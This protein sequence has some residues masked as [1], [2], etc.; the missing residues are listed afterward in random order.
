MPNGA[1]IASYVVGSIS[2]LLLITAVFL[3]V[4]LRDKE[5][6]VVTLTPSAVPNPTLPPKSLVNLAALNIQQEFG[7][8][9]FQVIISPITSVTTTISAFPSITSPTPTITPIGPGEF[10]FNSTIGLPLQIPSEG[11]GWMAILPDASQFFGSFLNGYSAWSQANF[12]TE[13][14]KSSFE[15]YQEG[16]TTGQNFV[17]FNSGEKCPNSGSSAAPTINEYSSAVG[18]LGYS[19]IATSKDGV[20]LYIAYRQ[21]FMGNTSDQALIF[22]LL[23]LPGYIACY[24]RPLDTSGTSLDPKSSAKDWTYSCIL[25]LANVFGSQTGG[26]DEICDPITHQILTGDSFGNIIRTSK[27][28]TN[29][30]RIVAARMNYGYVK[31]NGACITVFEETPDGVHQ[32]SGVI[33]L[34]NHYAGPGKTFSSNAKITFGNDFN[35]GNNAILA[36]IRVPAAG[37]CD[38]VPEPP[39]NQIIY[40]RRN[41]TTQVW[42]FQQVIDP[43]DPTE[44]F[45][46]S[47][48]MSPDGTMA[49]VGA[50]KF[51]SGRGIGATPGIG[52]SLYLYV[53]SDDAT[54]WSMKQ[55]IIDPFA[56]QNTKGC[57]G[58]FV[59]SDPQFLVISASAN[60]NN[61]L[62]IPPTVLGTASTLDYPKVVFLAV[63]QVNQTIDSTNAQIAIQPG[64]IS[65]QYFDPTFGANLAMSFVDGGKQTLRVLLNSPINQLVSLQ[66]MTVG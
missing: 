51:P 24:T 25:S 65:T 36:A 28:L 54:S 55:K 31:S 18:S 63:N 52:G 3:L 48:T 46:V 40:F 11:F 26:Y 41:A 29:S 32:V 38:G 12:V 49:I 1:Q 16:Y 27:N 9:D 64:N 42:E 20:R 7:I 8:N 10:D 59:S 53:R 47:I 30:R 22:P 50:P 58:Y 56:S 57:F 34:W 13:Q 44:D 15:P 5:H 35:I 37:G 6:T 4:F 39:V 23:Q 21:P 2:L 33:S 62:D 17:Y 60:Q 66:V 19:A 61:V 14:S 45:G 43:P